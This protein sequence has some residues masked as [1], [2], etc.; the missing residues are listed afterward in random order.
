MP[1][2]QQAWM[3]RFLLAC[4]VAGALPALCAMLWFLLYLYLGVFYIRHG[5]SQAF[6]EILTREEY[7]RWVFLAAAIILVAWLLA[8]RAYRGRWKR[9]G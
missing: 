4:L 7:V 2:G 5:D 8:L 3:R 1:N 9:G 6:V